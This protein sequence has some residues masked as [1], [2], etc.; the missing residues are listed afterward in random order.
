MHTQMYTT[1][2]HIVNAR[3]LGIPLSGLYLWARPQCP[4]ANGSF[5]RFR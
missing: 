2:V 3:V 5:M 4:M 1:F